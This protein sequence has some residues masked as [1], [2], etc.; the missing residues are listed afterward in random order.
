MAD[1]D[2]DAGSR[3]EEEAPRDP[4]SDETAASS[5]GRDTDVYPTQSGL[6]YGE[7]PPGPPD[8]TTTAHAMPG[9]AG[10]GSSQQPPPRSDSFR[11][12]V[13][14]KPAQIAGAGLIGLIL[15]ALLGGTAVAVVSNLA[16]RHDHHRM[17]W[18]YSEWGPQRPFVIPDRPAVSC[19]D[20]PD[21]VVFCPQR[22]GVEG[23]L[24]DPE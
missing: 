6:K 3:G 12:F 17:Y 18:E 11:D 13:R 20:L 24:P 1:H 16:D 2:R 4:T 23:V 19:Y 9:S 22:P 10:M 21:E 15:G 14:R 8:Y 5:S 7:I